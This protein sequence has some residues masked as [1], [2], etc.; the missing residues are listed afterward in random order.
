MT[1]TGRMVLNAF[2]TQVEY[3]FKNFAKNS[4]SF[5]G[6]ASEAWPGYLDAN[7][8]PCQNPAS[9]ISFSVYHPIGYT[10]NWVVKFD[11]VG[12]IMILSASTTV[13]DQDGCIVA[14]GGNTKI[15]SNAAS[16]ARGTTRVVINFTGP[17]SA[18]TFVFTGGATKYS[19]S[20][21]GASRVSLMQ[22]LVFCRASS[23]YGNG[24][25]TAS[26]DETEIA[27]GDLTRSFNDDTLAIYAP[28]NPK[29]LR[30]MGLQNINTSNISHHTTR[31]PIGAVSYLGQR[32]DPTLWSG[33]ASGTG[34]VYTCSANAAS[35][36][37]SLIDGEQVQVQFTNAQQSPVSLTAVLTN[38]TLVTCTI[39]DTTILGLSAFIKV[40]GLTDSGNTASNTGLEASYAPTIVNAT[41]FTI[42]TTGTFGGSVTGA[43]NCQPVPQITVGSKAAKPIV[44]ID[45]IAAATFWDNKGQITAGQ[46]GTLT[47][48]GL[49]QAWVVSSDG[50]VPCPPV[51]V[52]VALCKKVN[53]DLWWCFSV[54]MTTAECIAQAA[55]IRDGLNGTGLNAYFEYGNENWNPSFTQYH[56]CYSRGF[57][58]G[59]GVSSDQALM[60]YWGQRFAEIMGG[61]T[62]IWSGSAVLYRV[63]A[64][65]GGGAANTDTNLFLG[66]ALKSS[67]T[68]YWAKNPVDYSVNGNRPIDW[69]DF[70]SYAVYYSGAQ[71]KQFDANFAGSTSAKIADL[72]TAA[73]NYATGTPSLMTA[74]L[75]WLDNDVRQGTEAMIALTSI[76]ADGTIT[77][78]AHGR[79]NNE[80]VQLS[81]SG[82]LPSPYTAN[83]LYYISGATTNTF[84]LATSRNGTA[85]SSVS[86]GSGTHSYGTG[87]EGAT[88]LYW[89]TDRLNFWNAYA[90]TYN[91]GTVLYEGGQSSWYPLAATCT[92]LGI[93]TTYS[94]KILNLIIAYQRSQLM[95]QT[96]Y[97]QM[98]TFMTGSKSVMPCQ[99]QVVGEN[100]WSL[101]QGFTSAPLADGTQFSGDITC[102]QNAS[103]DSV[104]LFNANKQRF[105]GTI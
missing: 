74:A 55:V 88:M 67:S 29:V 75:A 13:L 40:P 35:P 18:R 16:E 3:L 91:K 24:G 4:V 82:T 84:K 61:I 26:G 1:A 86:G 33:T 60:S 81:S 100:A 59:F 56:I 44:N 9:N 46:F 31:T 83:T 14:A 5:G 37:S 15:R 103:W 62:A 25:A 80:I 101:L 92:T 90:V 36:S 77:L 95:M 34:G 28:L 64:F 58:Y 105:T 7:G 72:I 19:A 51:E 45:G 85:I 30:F 69:C 68:G 2:G 97:K 17:G 38:S 53:K 32:F 79:S 11:G 63:L 10:G 89:S 57:V 12:E 20:G 93:S 22:N 99:L 41:T 52:I 50:L 65:Q 47:Y 70:M 42:T 96:V 71:A 27:S 49:L 98:T 8:Y 39:A 6:S 48:D 54:Q 76:G 66:S 104:R 23:P 102:A 43:G 94:Q 87:Q 21:S 73:D 78:N